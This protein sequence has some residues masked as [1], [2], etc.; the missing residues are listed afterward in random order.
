MVVNDQCLPKSFESSFETPK[1]INT[2]GVMVLPG[3]PGKIKEIKA[4]CIK[5]QEKT[6]KLAINV[7]KEEGC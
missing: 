6:G 5:I 3:D 1:Y 4:Y 2:N 7:A